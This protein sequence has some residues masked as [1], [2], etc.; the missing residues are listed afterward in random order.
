MVSLDPAVPEQGVYDL[1]LYS[2]LVNEV[3]ILSSRGGTIVN[4]DDLRRL[5]EGDEL[6][7][8]YEG[9]LFGQV[10]PWKQG[11][12]PVEKSKK[13]VMANTFA[14]RAFRVEI[15]LDDGR[16]LS[17][18]LDWNG[19][20]FVDVGGHDA[21]LLRVVAGATQ[22]MLEDADPQVGFFETRHLYQ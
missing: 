4:S 10:V 3:C 16:T 13:S 19:R 7:L 14:S 22:T 21:V 17:V 1:I 5:T 2:G 20:Y 8:T 12:A 9:V 18:P 15:D 6:A 11:S